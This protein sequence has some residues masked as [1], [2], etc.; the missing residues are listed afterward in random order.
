MKISVATDLHYYNKSMGTKSPY[1]FNW[2]QSEIKMLAYSDVI[3]DAFIAAINE[4]RPDILILCGDLTNNGA[5][6]SHRALVEKLSAI[7][8]EIRTFLIPGNHDIGSESNYIFPDDSEPVKIESITKEQFCSIYSDYGYKNADSYAPDSLSYSINLNNQIKLIAIDSN[9]YNNRFP[10]INPDSG[11]LSAD[12]LN[13]IKEQ[14]IEA[15]SENL[16][17]I[18]FMHHPLIEHFPMLEM[19]FPDFILH[20]SRTILKTF[21]RLGINII[22]TGHHHANS[23]VS[24]VSNG[25]RVFDIQTSALTSY[26]LAFRTLELEDSKIKINSNYLKINLNING[27]SF[28]KHAFDFTHESIKMNIIK[29]SNAYANHQITDEQI[30]VLTETYMS[31]FTGQK[32]IT[33]RITKFLE[34]HKNSTDYIIKRIVLFVKNIMITT[35]NTDCYIIGL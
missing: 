3:I 28:E 2:S 34:E 14:A 13:W 24:K 26:P 8:P 19:L 25:Q 7:N 4:Q 6:I 31:Y 23:I 21:A 5:E 10:E 32:I 16:R 27:D 20:Q 29:F 1:F 30:E 15:Q 33:P 11:A 17:I 12:T 22:L 35:G 9:N 18:A